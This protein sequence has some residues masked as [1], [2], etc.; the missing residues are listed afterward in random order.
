MAARYQRRG[1]GRLMEGER[2]VATGSS[3]VTRLRYVVT[4]VLATCLVVGTILA[5][6]GGPSRAELHRA[7]R[8]ASYR[9][10]G[11]HMRPTRGDDPTARGGGR[12]AWVAP[13]RRYVPVGRMTIPAIGLS[14]PFFM[15]VHAS[16][17]NLGPG[18]W[19]GT[20]L[21]GERGNAVLAGHRTTHT[22]P[23][24]DLDL[25]RPG[26]VIRTRA[27]HR[28]ST[29]FRVTTTRIVPER[30]YVDVV[31]R[32]PGHRGVRMVTLF[33]CAPKG[34]RT[35]RIVVRA[36]ASAAG[37]RARATTKRLRAA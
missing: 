36:R 30:R 8:E 37:A 9:S 12:L 32:P 34:Y 13:P 5:L 31:L 17:V 29:T 7:L 6:V 21:P 10:A 33:A 4:T 35:F 23:F 3:R 19:P 18:L 25:L 22:H 27:R 28:G 14:T 26:D 1:A 20:P 15:G 16:V 24:L 2:E 11:P